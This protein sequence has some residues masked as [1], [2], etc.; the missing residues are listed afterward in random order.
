MKT[1]TFAV[2]I[3]LEL[4][5]VRGF[6]NSKGNLEWTV[7][8]EHSYSQGISGPGKFCVWTERKLRFPECTDSE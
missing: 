7:K 4:V 6:I 2:K 8:G 3:G 1:K 5:K